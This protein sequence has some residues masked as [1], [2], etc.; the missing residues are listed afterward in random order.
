MVVGLGD[1][2]VDALL[3]RPPELLLVLR[4]HHRAG[5]RRVLGVVRP[6]VA[7]VP[8]H[9]RVALAGDLAGDP[10]GLAVHRLEVVGAADVLELL[11]VRVVGERDHHVRARAQELAMQLAQRVGRVEDHFRHE[12]AGLDVAAAL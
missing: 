11:A 8:G 10:H 2:E 4:A 12:R 1:H 5:C 6:R 3:D 7:D 9:Q